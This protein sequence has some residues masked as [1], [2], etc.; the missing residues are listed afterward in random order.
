[1]TK[2]EALKLALDGHKVRHTHWNLD[3]FLIW[4]NGQF[5]V[6][7]DVYDVNFT[8]NDGWELFSEPKQKKLVKMYAPIIQHGGVY[9][10][11]HHYH[12]NK[13]IFSSQL[14]AVGF[15]EIEVEVS[16]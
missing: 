15:H 16:E 2:I 12:N 8:E 11:D 1:M 7:Y 3:L 9:Y 5:F 13:K 4:Q 6:G 14:N 10:T